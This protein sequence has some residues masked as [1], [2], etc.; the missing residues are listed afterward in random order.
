MKELLVV[1]SNGWN[2]EFSSIVFLYFGGRSSSG[3]GGSEDFGEVFGPPNTN[4]IF[5][6]PNIDNPRTFDDF[7]PIALC[8]SVYNIISK[9]FVVR[10]K[11]LLSS[12]ISLE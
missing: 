5:L 8:N 4:F 3:C 1:L 9:A 11:R 2:V 12:I 10:F 6:I 7:N